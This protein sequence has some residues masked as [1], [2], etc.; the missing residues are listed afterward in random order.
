MEFLCRSPDCSLPNRP[1]EPELLFRMLLKMGQAQ[2]GCLR[3]VFLGLL[4]LKG[5]KAQQGSI[6]HCPQSVSTPLCETSM[7]V[8]ACPLL[9]LQC[10][11]WPLHIVLFLKYWFHDG[12]SSHLAYEE[13]AQKC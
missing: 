10:L 2:H 6:Q 3:E 5:P 9:G 11:K 7:G 1:E 12:S 13:F 4:Q 8:W